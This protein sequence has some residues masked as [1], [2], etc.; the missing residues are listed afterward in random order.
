MTRR[1]CD[2]LAAFVDGQLPDSEADLFRTHLRDCAACE[3]ATLD[4]VWINAVLGPPRRPPLR[5]RAVS[6]L[7]DDPRPLPVRLIGYAVSGAASAAVCVLALDS[8]LWAASIAQ[9]LV[10]SS[11]EIVRGLRIRARVRRRLPAA[12]ARS[13]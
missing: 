4:Q 3:D 12:R 7:F 5:R 9:I 13:V 2:D 8:P 6:W 11:V 10:A 1:L